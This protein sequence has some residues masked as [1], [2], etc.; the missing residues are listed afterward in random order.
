MAVLTEFQDQKIGE[1]LLLKAEQLIAKLD[2][3]TIWCNVRTSAIGIYEKNQ[4]L[5]IGNV[6]KIPDVGS[7][8]LMYKYL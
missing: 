3:D 5:Q 1:L 4:Y 6:F 8:V 2:I 7:H